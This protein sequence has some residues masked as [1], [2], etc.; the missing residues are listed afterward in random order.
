MT[1][2]LATAGLVAVLGLTAVAGCSGGQSSTTDPEARVTT[3]PGGI[4]TLLSVD[5][6]GTWDP[7]RIGDPV[8]ASLSGRLLHRTLTAYAP[9]TDGPSGASAG[10]LVGDLAT[11]TGK[12]STD[13]RTWTFTL[14]DDVRW[15]DGSAVTCDDVRHGIART[16]STEA[17]TGGA[18]DALAVLDVPKTP[19]GKSIYRGPWA[20]GADVEA[21]RRAFE[22]AVSCD[23]RQVTFTLAVPVADFDEVLTQAAFAPVKAA[24]DTAPPPADSSGTVDGSVVLASNGPYVLQGDWDPRMGGTF[25]RNPNWS[26]SADAVRKAYPDKIVIEAGLP[27]ADVVSRVV[28]DR[29][30]GVNAV[31]LTPAPDPLRQE[32]AA[33]P[34]LRART[35][36]A[37]TELV[38]YL[39]LNVTSPTLSRAEIR[40]AVALATNRTG[41]AV[42]LG[43]PQSARPVGSIIP[44]TMIARS[45]TPAPVLAADPAAAR[46]LLRSAGVTAP[47][48]LRI[49]YR[50]S[51]R[52]DKAMAAL[53][54]SWQEAGFAPE[55]KPIAKDYFTAI[56]APTAA[57]DHDIFWSSWSPAWGS[58]STILPALFDPTLNLS[59]ASSGRDVGLWSDADWTASLA[60][61]SSLADRM[62]REKA[63]A[64]ADDKLLSA[65]AY[66]A[67]TEGRAIH[68][69]GSG[70]GNLASAPHSGGTPDLAV[71]GVAH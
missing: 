48:P 50:P 10:R 35:L 36:V 8:V 62:A 68:L 42:S 37:D 22:A 56:S 30:N 31:S 60:P 34:S 16:F 38:D 25:V 32:L 21:A 15:Q 46:D 55:L 5:P 57:A 4:L 69:A 49:A 29:D 41:Y 40:Q 47:V 7:Q 67:L 39:A 23:G 19:D 52:Q 14:R 9:G 20:T 33:I 61:I 64:A 70:V 43:G 26:R 28:G 6:I 17:V 54:A 24:V 45:V 65:A 71:L 59:A 12:P 13:R 18:L 1:R 53:V 11:D 58:A 27:M 3:T 66:V 63:W 44:S 2:R 51:P